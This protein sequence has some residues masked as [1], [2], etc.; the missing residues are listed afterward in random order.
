MSN[1]NGFTVTFIPWE[2]MD[3]KERVIGRFKTEQEKNDFL[4]EIYKPNSGWMEEELSTV[5]VINSYTY[6]LPR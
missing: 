2:D 1:N 4:N 6:M 5:S 3:G